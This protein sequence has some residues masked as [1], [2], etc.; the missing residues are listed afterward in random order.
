MIMAGKRLAIYRG[1][2]LLGFIRARA[3]N[4]RLVE[5]QSPAQGMEWVIKGQ[6]DGASAH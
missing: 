4:V 3:P 1:H 2:P 6:A 5:V